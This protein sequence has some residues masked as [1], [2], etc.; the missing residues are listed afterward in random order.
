[1]SIEIWMFIAN[2]V[3]HWGSLL[4]GGLIAVA[5]LAIEHWLN[6]NITWRTFVYVVGVALFISCFLAWHD[7]HHNRRS[8]DCSKVFSCWPESTTTATG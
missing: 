2:V 8:F 3:S 5:I 4:T 1:M 7:E 6:R